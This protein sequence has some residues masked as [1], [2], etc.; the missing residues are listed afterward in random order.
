MRLAV[1]ELEAASAKMGRKQ[2]SP[3]QQPAPGLA[4]RLYRFFAEDR[5]SAA[6]WRQADATVAE[7]AR[8]VAEAHAGEGAHAPN[9][10]KL[11]RLPLKLCPA[12]AP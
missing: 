9:T 7:R 4:Q 12:A 8:M 10:T 2:P 6:E 5:E 11:S 1:Q 3:Q